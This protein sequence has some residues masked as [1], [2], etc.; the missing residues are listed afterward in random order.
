MRQLDVTD[1]LSE[2]DLIILGI[3]GSIRERSKHEMEPHGE[4]CG[5]TW[6]VF[7]PVPDT[8][9][10]PLFWNN[11]LEYFEIHEF[12]SSLSCG[13]NDMGSTPK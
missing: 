8:E 10:A 3:V 2:L 11:L 7:P 4:I 12:L 5:V 9:R 13:L 1:H 6:T